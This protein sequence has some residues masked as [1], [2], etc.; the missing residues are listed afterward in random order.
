[1][2]W[3]D[4]LLK[5]WAHLSEDV[6]EKVREYYRR[7]GAAR[8]HGGPLLSEQVQTLVQELQTEA[9]TLGA[10]HG[11]G[12]HMSWFEFLIARWEMLPED[13]HQQLKAYDQLERAARLQAH[14]SLIIKIQPL[15]TAL[16]KSARQYGWKEEAP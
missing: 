5:Y 10:G 2:T 13:I 4:V 11:K 3:R 9:R 12:V 16:K 7:R 1:M 15:E 14:R 6:Q 8:Q